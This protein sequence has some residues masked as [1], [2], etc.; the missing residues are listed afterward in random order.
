[1]EPKT[2]VACPIKTKELGNWFLAF[3]F[4]VEYIT[5]LLNRSI[6]RKISQPFLATFQAMILLVYRK[7]WLRSFTTYTDSL[8]SCVELHAKTHRSQ[9]RKYCYNLDIQIANS[10]VHPHQSVWHFLCDSLAQQ[11]SG[12]QLLLDNRNRLDHSL[13][14]RTPATNRS[15][16]TSFKFRLHS[17][18]LEA[19]K[20]LLN[21]ISSRLL[22]LHQ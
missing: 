3:P 2:P 20:T 14:T 16:S 22:L 19:G 21:F 18:F 9:N 15:Q 5:I 1:L 4:G 8:D 10:L 6:S 11:S 13:W 17:G 7:I 12:H